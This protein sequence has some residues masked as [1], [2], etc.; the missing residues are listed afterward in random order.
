MA[1]SYLFVNKQVDYNYIS[2]VAKLFPISY[3]EYVLFS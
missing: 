2:S 3:I 1:F